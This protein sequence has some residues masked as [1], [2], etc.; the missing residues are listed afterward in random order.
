M[1]DQP[2]VPSTDGT[3]EPTPYAAPPAPPAPPPPPAPAPA[4]AAPP[5]WGQGVAPT[6]YP[7]PAAPPQP[8]PYGGYGQAPAYA[9]GAGLP[10]SLAY[11]QA[12]YGP[13]ASFGQRAGALLIDVLLSMIG[14]IPVIIGF[15][16]FAASAGSTTYDEY[17]NPM[18]ESTNGGGA[19]IG[20][21]LIFVGIVLGFAI[22]VWNRI[23]KMGRTGQ[24][25]GKK[26]VVLTLIGTTTFH[27]TAL[28]CLLPT[29]F[30][31]IHGI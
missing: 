26:V 6:P 31:H 10:G 21:L 17:G 4:P 15:I 9:G 8:N 24:S 3:Q 11:V 27:P 25:V 20:G 16:I 28:Y 13:V 22:Q 18:L 29:I 12:N 7:G 5:A 30:Y 2:V 14:I 19:V 1:S 23:F